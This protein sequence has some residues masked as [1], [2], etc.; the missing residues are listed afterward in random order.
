MTQATQSLRLGVALPQTEFAGDPAA[1]R[2]F[3]QASEELGYH[4]LVTYDHVLGANPGVADSDGPKDLICDPFVLLGFM[5]ACTRRIELSIQVL[6]L[7]QRQTVLV[8]KQAASLD[9]L[10]DGR[11]RLGVGVGWNEV[12]FVGLGENFKN[13]GR[14]SEEQVELMRALWAEPYI[15]FEGN[16]HKVPDAEI[17]PPPGRDIPLWFGG[18]ADVTLRRIAKM[19]D[20]WMPLAYPPD[21]TARGEVEKLRCYAEETGRG[22]GDI[23]IDAWVSMGSKDP[24]A[25]RDEVKGWRECGATHLTLTTAFSAYHHERIEGTTLAAHL[26]AIKRYRE[27]VADLL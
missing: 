3:V 15:S 24:E 7:P 5:A 18:H 23:G 14:R 22:P 2:D 25:W 19:G 8:A 6:I 1:M 4:H 17:N 21:D 20:G 13:R 10:C 27:A 16:W 11:L 26:D 9:V 12:E